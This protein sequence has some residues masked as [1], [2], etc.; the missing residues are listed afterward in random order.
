M[1][2]AVVRLPQALDTTPAASTYGSNRGG[3]AGRVGPVRE[4]LETNWPTPQSRDEKGLTGQHGRERRSSL[5][6]EV[7]LLP[8]TGGRLNPAWVL[9]LNPP[10]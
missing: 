10:G 3:S 8:A 4:S 5:S 7:I 6:D 1:T 2:D 9:T